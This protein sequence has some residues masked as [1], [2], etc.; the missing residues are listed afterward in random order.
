MT[1]R[2][3]DF[4]ASFFG[5]IVLLPLFVFIAALIK[6]DSKGT[7]FYLQS[8][9]GKFNN[10]FKLI[11]FRT[12]VPHAD[13][14]SLI[15]LSSRDG[16]ITKIG[17]HLRKYKIDE[18]PQLFNVLKGEMSLVGPR[19]EVRKYVEKYNQEQ[20]KVLN[21]RPGLTDISSIVYSNENEILEKEDNP[22]K[23]YTDVIMPEKLYRN[24]KYLKERSFFS[25]L[26]IIFLTFKKIL[27]V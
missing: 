6:I 4:L 18:L 17:Y 14:G 21:Y 12:M 8:R 7:I 23:Y 27:R 10:N 19:P 1:K 16:R 11:K 5:I 2:L 15:T 22:E 13:K 25:D 9:V 3:F 26:K 24:L 20:L